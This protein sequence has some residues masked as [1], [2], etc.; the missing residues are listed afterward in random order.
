MW[1]LY[2]GW[3]L[4]TFRRDLLF[5]SSDCRQNTSTLNVEAVGTF[6]GLVS[7][8]QAT[9]HYFL[10]NNVPCNYQ[11]RSRKTQVYLICVIGQFELGVLEYLNSSTT[12]IVTIAIMLLKL[13]NLAW[14]G[15]FHCEGPEII[16]DLVLNP[17]RLL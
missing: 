3:N 7:L 14:S 8:Y 5:P 6:K 4:L 2:S 11:W 13:L 1:Y 12:V 9:Q 15:K 16:A 10:A 17:L